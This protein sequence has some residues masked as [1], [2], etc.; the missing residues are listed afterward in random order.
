VC[1]RH[2]L[3]FRA[4][5]EK[6]VAALAQIIGIVLAITERNLTPKAAVMH[7]AKDAFSQPVSNLSSASSPS[8]SSKSDSLK[9]AVPPRNSP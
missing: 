6:K 9:K 1:H 8:L 7:V 2:Q 4:G 3:R 5:Q